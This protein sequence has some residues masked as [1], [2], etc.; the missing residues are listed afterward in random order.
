VGPQILVTE[1]ARV[2]RKPPQDIDACDLVL[3]AVPHMW[4]LNGQELARA[5]ELLQ[6]AIALDPNYARA[7]ALLGWVYVTMSNLDARRPIGEFTDKALAAGATA[8]MLDDDE[9]WGHLALGLGHA[10][11]RRPELGIW[12]LSKS[13]ELNPSF[14][15]AHA[16]LGYALAVS[17]QP[18]R[19]LQSLEQA[20]R[21]SP[22]DPFLAAYAP[23]VQY[24]ALFALK[25]YEESIAVCRATAV[26]HPN[27][28]GAWRLLAVSLGLIGRIDE[29][30]E[31]LAHSLTLQ[32]DP[33][34]DTI[35]ADAADHARFLE[36]L[37]KAGWVM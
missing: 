2:Q 30:R 33:S 36:G 14:A 31:A 29:A 24:T 7:H 6:R 19:G 34:N 11:R 25:R 8:V 32:P 20:H 22:C 16:G 3:Q 17:G 5:E 4:H 27:H 28:A 35:Y 26:L 37:R 12:H 15:L 1:A 10:R 9:P 21:L 23:V 13:V 18:E